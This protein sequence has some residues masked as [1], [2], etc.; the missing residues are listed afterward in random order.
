MQ[1]RINKELALLRREYPDLEYRPDGRW[2]RIPAYTLP[3][4]WSRETTAVAFDIPP[5]FPAGPPYGIYVPAG[6]TFNGQRPDNYTEPAS[7]QPPFGGTWGV[8]SWTT[9]DG[10]WRATAEPDALRGC[11]LLSWVNG[12]ADRFRDGK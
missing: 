2:V 11:S 7:K 12:F 8:L 1:E 3:A 4:G 9:V 10:R 5:E 6:L